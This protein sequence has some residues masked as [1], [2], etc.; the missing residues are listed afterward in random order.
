MDPINYI[1]LETVIYPEQK[2]RLTVS[3]DQNLTDQIKSIN[4]YLENN[5]SLNINSQGKDFRSFYHIHNA[6]LDVQPFNDWNQ[7]HDT[8]KFSAKLIGQN[9][10]ELIL[11]VNESIEDLSVFEK[12]N[13]IAIE[14]LKINKNNP[15]KKEEENQF[16]NLKIEKVEQPN[17]I[18]NKS[19]KQVMESFPLEF[20]D[21]E[22]EQFYIQG[23]FSFRNREYEIK[24]HNH[25]KIET[26][27]KEIKEKLEEGNPSIRVLG[28]QISI[29]DGKNQ[30]IHPH[31]P[32]AHVIS[33]SNST[34]SIAF[35][36]NQSSDLVKVRFIL[37]GQGIQE[38]ELPPTTTLRSLQ[39]QMLNKYFSK[40]YFNGLKISLSNKPDEKVDQFSTMEELVKKYGLFKLNH[41]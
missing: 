3:I 29:S 20:E 19:E 41:Y 1:I 25:D 38:I 23:K 28:D 15:Q 16:S 36:E 9:E 18:E 22:S 40:R 27:Q 10:L 4:E 24:C 6:T 14:I 7:G 11:N 13:L 12:L 30:K 32:L 26:W 17:I 39:A 33:R 2:K 8:N 34:C 5:Y 21:S 31:Q 37:E 35:L